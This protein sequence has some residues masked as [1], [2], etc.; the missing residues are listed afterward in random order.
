MDPNGQHPEEQAR[1]NRLGT[2]HHEEGCGD[3]NSH[4]LCG[5]K[6]SESGVAPNYELHD[7]DR[8]PHKEKGE[9]DERAAFEADALFEPLK[10]ATPR[11][12]ESFMLRTISA[13]STTKTLRV[14]DQSSSGATSL[15]P[16]DL[17]SQI[18]VC[19]YRRI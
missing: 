11:Y 2:Q 17:L 19:C 6:R 13:L 18:R 10:I 4:S 7:P 16:N 9:P 1:H 8:E 14:S 5:I 12:S 3:G 15:Q